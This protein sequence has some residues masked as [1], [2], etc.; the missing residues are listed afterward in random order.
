MKKLLAIIK[1][2]YMQRLR[3]KAFLILTILGP[4][5]TI[6]MMVLPALIFSMKAGGPTR[7]AVLDQS[8]KMYARI[9]DAMAREEDDEDEIDSRKNDDAV[10][11]SAGP[12]ERMK[13]AGAANAQA[14][15]VEQAQLGSRT[16]EEVK[17]ELSERVRLD[18]LDGYLIVPPDVLAT[19][20]VEYYGRNVGDVVTRSQ[21]EARLNRA[22]FEQRVAE[23]HISTQLVR[24][25]SRRLDVTTIKISD[26]GEEKDTG[27]GFFLVLTIG[28]FI[29]LM[30][31]MYG[32]TILGA[33][34]EEK[35]TRMAE[36]LF[37]S[38]R[39]F[40]LMMGKLIGVSLLALTQYAVWGAASVL[41]TLY[42][43]GALASSGMEATLPGVHW[44]ILVYFVIFSLLGYFIYSTF[45]LLVGAMVT[46]TQEGGQV[47]LPV[48][49]LLI[50]A[51]MLIFPVIRSPDSSLAFWISLIP[52]FSPIIMPVRIVTQTPPAW[53]IA[54]SLLI[55]WCTVMLLIWTAARVYRIGM[56]MYGKRASIPEVLRWLRQA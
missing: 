43:A 3:S 47:A 35:E 23:A 12:E 34:I 28:V 19:S 4:I 42:G 45:Y 26:R 18:E 9:Q 51:Y 46:T 17:R 33:V 53:Q 27:G 39:A 13:K 52:F 37:S 29:L 6:G 2:E 44:S 1:R 7:L 30:I 32:Q 36:M 20:R 24:E 54:L 16:L 14:F 48:T 41:F 49:F 10:P 55:G 50:A 15:M 21:L 8:G 40:P 56:L 31:T 5:M 22:V 25:M 11:A 38:V